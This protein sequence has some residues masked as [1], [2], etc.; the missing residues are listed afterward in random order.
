MSHD[1]S[2]EVDNFSGS[3][4]EGERVAATADNSIL[5]SW[6]TGFDTGKGENKATAKQTAWLGS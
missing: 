1:L 6:A 3:G 5:Q 2:R 4:R